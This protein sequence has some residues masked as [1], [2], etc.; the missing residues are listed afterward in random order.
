MADPLDVRA[1]KSL[2]SELG[3]KLI[4]VTQADVRVMHG[5]A[6]IRGVVK[7]IVGGPTDTKAALNLACSGLR[8][9]GVIKDF[10]IDCVYRS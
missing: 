4:D 9:K 3:K 5:T 6:Y 7:P 10:V 1:S 2:R 8:Q